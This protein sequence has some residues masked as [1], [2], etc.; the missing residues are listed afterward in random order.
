[1]YK[2]YPSL[3]TI[4]N[5]KTVTKIYSGKDDCCR[6]GCG[7]TY[8][9]PYNKRFNYVLKKA[10]EALCDLETADATH[11]SRFMLDDTAY[12]NIPRYDESKDSHKDRNLCYCV[13]FKKN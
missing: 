6:C 9:Y 2:A 11:H 13:Y 10:S 8:I 5:G 7:G 12:V 1:M 4:L 3:K